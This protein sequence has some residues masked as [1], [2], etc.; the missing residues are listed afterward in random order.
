MFHFKKRLYRK[1]PSDAIQFHDGCVF[2]LKDPWNPKYRLLWIAGVTSRGTDFGASLIAKN[3]Q[4]YETEAKRSVGLVFRREFKADQIVSEK[5][6]WLQPLG[7][8]LYWHGTLD[9][10]SSS[11]SQLPHG[12]I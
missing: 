11:T 1:D 12:C 8:S 9:D 10:E 4:G 6:S 7:K 5:L 2:L 3:W